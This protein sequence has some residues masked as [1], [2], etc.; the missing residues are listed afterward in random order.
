MS[1]EMLRIARRR[2]ANIK[3]VDL[4]IFDLSLNDDTQS[5]VI[6]IHVLQHLPT[7]QSALEQLM[8]ITRDK[9]IV[10]S[11]FH[12]DS[13]DKIQ[14]CDPADN[15]DHQRFHNNHYSLPRFLDFIRENSSKPFN[16]I[17]VHHFGS[18]NFAVCVDF[19]E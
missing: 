16:D 18:S 4:D 9:L 1:H 12:E 17:R 8:R 7:Y 10:V 11:W 15:W 14:F 6:N 2:F 5:N 3:F 13:E 19:T